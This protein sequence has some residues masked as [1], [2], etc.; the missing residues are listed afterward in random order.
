METNGR[1]KIYNFYTTARFLCQYT[2]VLFWEK[3]AKSLSSL[4]VLNSANRIFDKPLVLIS[5]S[6]HSLELENEP[7][8]LSLKMEAKKDIKSYWKEK[9]QQHPIAIETPTYT[10]MLVKKSKTK[11]YFAKFIIFSNSKNTGDEYIGKRKVG[12]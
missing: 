7:T 12:G 4:F 2:V 10:H 9:Q 8:S 11:K 1:M 5:L 6:W 3:I